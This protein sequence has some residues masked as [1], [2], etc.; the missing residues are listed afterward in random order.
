MMLIHLFSLLLVTISRKKTDDVSFFLLSDGGESKLATNINYFIE[1]YGIYVNKDCLVRS[2]YHSKAI[3]TNCVLTDAPTLPALATV[4]S[5]TDSRPSNPNSAVLPPIIFPDAATLNVQEPAVPLFL[6]GN[7]SYPVNR[8]LAAACLVPTDS[9]QT[10]SDPLKKITLF[11]RLFY[12]NSYLADVLFRVSTSP[13]DPASFDILDSIF[14]SLSSSTFQTT[15]DVADYIAVPEIGAWATR[16]KTKLQSQPLTVMTDPLNLIDDT[17]FSFNTSNIPLAGRLFSELELPHQPLTLIKPQFDAPL[18]ALTPSVFV[19]SALEPAPPAL[20]LFDLDEEWASESVSLSKLMSKCKG[21]KDL[22][23][24]IKEASKLLGVSKKLPK[25]QQ[26]SKSFMF[27]VMKQLI[28][29]KKLNMLGPDA[30]PIQT[31]EK[32]GVESKEG[33][34]DVLTVIN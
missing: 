26:N 11:G 22:D 5:T 14:E 19:P 29:F 6:S 32:I 18:P 20:E 23:F 3:P 28:G 24:F 21:E 10:C 8:P 2:V 15:Q 16:P 9:S 4:L 31:K 25:S 34:A 7:L 27:F 12:K 1:K 13:S 30:S 17:L 33:G